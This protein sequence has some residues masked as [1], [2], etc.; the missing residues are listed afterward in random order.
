HSVQDEKPF[1]YEAEGKFISFKPTGMWW[2][3]PQGKTAARSVTPAIGSLTKGK[4]KYPSALG[5]DIDIVCSTERTRWRKEIIIKSLQSLGAIPINAEYLEIGFELE[6][7]FEIGGWNKKSELKFN[8]AVKLSE[9]SQLES[10]KTWDNHIILEPKEDE[11]PEDPFERCGG[12]LKVVDGKYFLVKR[13]PADYL[14]DAVYPVATDVEIAYGSEYPFN[15]ADTTY[16]SCAALDDT[17]FVV[18]FRDDGGD[19]HG[20]AMI[21][22]VTGDAIAYGSEYP[23]NAAITSYISYAR[24]DDT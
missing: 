8:T 10:I 22:V 11:E 24:L 7:D 14:R 17:H 23:F 13:I 5:N 16:I 15:T 12:F 21:G 6:T 1:T 19:S 2:T 3:T 18:G 20:I 4:V 9:L